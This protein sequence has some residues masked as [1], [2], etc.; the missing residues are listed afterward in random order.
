MIGSHY[1][2]IFIIYCVYILS[3][4]KHILCKD[5]KNKNSPNIIDSYPS[6]KSPEKSDVYNDKIKY[7]NNNNNSRE[8]KRV[9]NIGQ[10]QNEPLY[11]H[12][13]HMFNFANSD[14]DNDIIVHFYSIDC[15]I[16]IYEKD[17]NINITNIKYYEFDAFLAIVPKDK[18]S[19]TEFQIWPIMYSYKDYYKNKAYHLII[20][21]FEEKENDYSELLLK[22]KEPNFL[23]FNS[24]LNKIKIT[25][26]LKE[27]IKETIY[28]SFFIN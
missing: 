8:I 22:E 23:F 14:A 1:K 15:P 11:N 18:L 24:K 28:V 19:S 20:N 9:I 4:Y 13:I 5:I 7:N 25:F 3:I 12:K 2:T 27:K 6:L 10:I 17:N 26:E 21:S 16:E